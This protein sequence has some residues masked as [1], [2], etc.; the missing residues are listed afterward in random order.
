MVS[1]LHSLVIFLFI[2][3][4]IPQLPPYVYKYEIVLQD[5]GYAPYNIRVRLIRKIISK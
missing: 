2:L 4:A 3:L 5:I 1:I